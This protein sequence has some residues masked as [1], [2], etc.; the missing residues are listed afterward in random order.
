MHLS[1][2]RQKR[3]EWIGGRAL[4]LL[5]HYYREDDPVELTGAMGKDWADV[6]EGIP[7]E[8]IQR[9]CIQYERDEPRRRPTPGDIYQRARAMI[10][11]PTVV[12]EAPAP[13]RAP[14]VS[15]ED[16]ARIL[17]RHNFNPRRFK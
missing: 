10:P 3:R 8:Y 16:A 13:Q 17:E 15:R 2:E 9:A 14:R 7:A 1:V 4:T 5:S 6:L 11:P 12:A